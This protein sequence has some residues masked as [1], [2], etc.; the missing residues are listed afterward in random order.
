[1]GK[2][3]ID[4]VENQIKRR[5]ELTLLQVLGPVVVSHLLGHL[6]P[7]RLHVLAEDPDVGHVGFEESRLD[8]EHFD[9]EGLH[10]Y[11]GGGKKN[12]FTPVWDQRLLTYEPD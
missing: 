4:K 3:K 9:T 11:P 10:V 6:L 12:S 2:S 8:A 5:P 1:M 7:H